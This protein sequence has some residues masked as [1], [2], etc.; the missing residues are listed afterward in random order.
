MEEVRYMISEAS[1]R[2]DV[3]AHVLRYWEEELEL[4][5]ARNEMGHRYYKEADIEL[6]KTVKE[7]K[8]QGFQLKAVRMLLPNFNKLD[9]LDSNTMI[10]LKEELNKRVMEVY[11]DEKL[12]DGDGTS[13]VPQEETETVAVNKHS[14]D[15]MEQFKAILNRVV[16]DALQENND[17]LSKSIGAHVTEKVIKEMNYLMK[18]QEEK[19]EERFRKF[20]MTLR[21]YQKTRSM[22]AVTIDGK[23]RKKSKF[24]K[25]N[26]VYL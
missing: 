19:E 12:Q 15:K 20:D 13:I 5:I 24:F 4:P 23:G 7:L 10:R 6:L 17:H 18:V 1:K 26:K 22:A 3:E 16:Q 14:D 2:V 8:E 11:S 9:K 21:D 25:K